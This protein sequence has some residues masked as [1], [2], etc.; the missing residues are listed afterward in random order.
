MGSSTRHAT[1]MGRSSRRVRREARRVERLRRGQEGPLQRLTLDV[2]HALQKGASPP[3]AAQ[4]AYA[5]Q[6]A[7]D[8]WLPEA[9]HR[10]EILLE[11]WP[12]ENC[13][14]PKIGETVGQ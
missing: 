10:L 4:Q 7:A 14:P 6:Q 1:T 5:A 13:V 8:P 3:A 12:Q 9:A 2:E 11:R